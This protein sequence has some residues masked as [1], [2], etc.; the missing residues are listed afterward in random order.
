MLII[1]PPTVLHNP[2]R[3]SWC[4]LTM[5]GPRDKRHPCLFAVHHPV[6]S[7]AKEVKCNFVIGCQ[8][9][10]PSLR[11]VW[12]CQEE[13]QLAF[14]DIKKACLTDEQGKFCNCAGKVWKVQ[15]RRWHAA[16][17]IVSRCGAGFYGQETSRF[18][19]LSF[20]NVIQS[21]TAAL[22]LEAV[23]RN[24]CVSV[25]HGTFICTAIKRLS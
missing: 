3:A 17:D 10:E 4:S 16:N 24:C 11:L 15:N 12:L 13:W 1:C 8:E 18:G 25:F 20:H 22:M 6:S 23:D 5:P 9:L 19:T 7:L 2:S 21:L 14:P